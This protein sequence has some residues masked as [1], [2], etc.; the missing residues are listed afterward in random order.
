MY[1]QVFCFPNE[2]FQE[3]NTPRLCSFLFRREVT[4]SVGKY[5]VDPPRVLFRFCLP[6]KKTQSGL[7]FLP[8]PPSHLVLSPYG[9]RGMLCTRFPG[10]INFLAFEAWSWKTVFVVSS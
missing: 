9:E 4:L 3:S 5:D 10:V 8:L 6:A 7:L 1:A 2:D